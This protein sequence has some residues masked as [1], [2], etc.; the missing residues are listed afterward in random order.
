MIKPY[1][2]S[3]IRT[4]RD[5][6]RNLDN[7]LRCKHASMLTNGNKIISMG[8]NKS[9]S[10]PFQKMN[11]NNHKNTSTYQEYS[12]THAEVD[13]LKGIDEVFRKSTLYVVRSDNKG[14]LMESCPCNGC[15]DLINKLKIP[16]IV[17]SNMDGGITVILNKVF[18]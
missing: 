3:Y 5:I 12:W 13:C 15:R 14:N 9:K 2:M 11:S 6:A 18:K 16:R 7:G 17:H 1:E 4:L 10:D 8:V